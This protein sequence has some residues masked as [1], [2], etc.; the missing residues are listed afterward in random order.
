[1]STKAITVAKSLLPVSTSEVREVMEAALAP[2]EHISVSDLPVIKVP[3]GGS[4][5]WE[6]PNGE[7]TKEIDAVL[8]HR[9]PTRA[10]WA[11]K[12]GAGPPDCSSQDAREGHGRY[13]VGSVENPSGMCP[14]DPMNPKVGECPMAQWGTKVNESGDSTMGQACALRTRLF[15]LLDGDILPTVLSAPPT[16]F[17]GAKGYVVRQRKPFWRLRTGI[18]LSQMKQG[19][20]A[21]SVPVFRVIEELSPEQSEEA[22]NYRALLLPVVSSMAVGE[23]A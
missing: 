22:D 4:Q 15:L 9:Q 2:G 19:A 20:Q 23:E 18:S 6:L 1:M 5:L 12:E 3:T 11:S 17:K 14:A 7:G 13:G 16:A 8:F 21:Y 10:F